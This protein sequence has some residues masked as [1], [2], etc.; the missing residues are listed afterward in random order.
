MAI[1]TCNSLDNTL[2]S[3]LMGMMAEKEQEQV[4]SQSPS[5]IAM[6]LAG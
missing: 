4:G 2:R 6:V 3:I 5:S 1:Q